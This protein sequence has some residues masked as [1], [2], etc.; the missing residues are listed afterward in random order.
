MGIVERKRLQSVGA[1]V[2]VTREA[3]LDGLEGEER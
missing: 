3:F 2:F 1:E